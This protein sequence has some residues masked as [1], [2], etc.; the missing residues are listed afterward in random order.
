M[1]LKIGTRGSKLALWQANYVV[2]LLKKGGIKA[3]VIIIS[4]RGDKKQDVSIAEIGTRGVFTEEIEEQLSA[5]KIDI[6]VHSAKDMQS[7]LPEEYELIAFT[8]REVVNDVVVSHDSSISLGDGSKPLTVGTSSARRKAL[9]KHYYPHIKTVE[10]RGNL[11]TRIKKME[12]GDCDA[13]LLAYAGVHRMDYHH[14][15]IKKLDT[16]SFT[17]AVGQGSVAIETLS[18]METEKKQL[19]QKLLSH[20]VSAQRLIAE[21][22]FLKT[23]RGGCSIPAFA[24]ATVEGNTMSI[25][26]GIVSLDGQ[27]MVRDKVQGSVK[28]ANFL[29]EDLANTLLNN[30]GKE[31]LEGIKSHNN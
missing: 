22:A 7:E 12:S 23:L 14:L 8:E 26:G 15:I 9:L 17:P 1:T 30:G 20:P 24:L 10:M 16:V 27:E 29:G 6:A 2:E 21:R 25:N 3:E 11:Q 19:L 28:N 4:T 31:I 13:M 18:S 5:G